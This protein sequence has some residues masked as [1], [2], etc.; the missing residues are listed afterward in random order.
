MSLNRRRAS[1]KLSGRSIVVC[2]FL[3]AAP[4]IFLAVPSTAETRIGE[5]ANKLTTTRDLAVPNFTQPLGQCVAPPAGMLAWYPGDG[6]NN[7]ILRGNTGVTNGSVL[8]GAGEVGQAFQFNGATGNAVSA[9]EQAAYQ[10]TSLTID[11]W[12]KVAA[13]PT[14]TQ[15]AG[16][17]FFRGDS[18]PALDPYFIYTAPGGKVGFHIESATGTVVQIDT[19]APANQWIHVAGTFDDPT[20]TMR[21]YV[22]GTLAVQ[23]STTVVPMTTMTGANPGIGIGNIHVTPFTFPFNGSI[24]EVELFGR[25]LSGAE[26]QGLYS[27]GVD[28]KCKPDSDADGVTDA[29][30]ACPATPSGSTVNAAGC[31][32]TE[33]LAPPPDMVAWYPGN[34]N[35]NDIVGG[36]Q[37]TTNG[38][39]NFAAGEVNQAF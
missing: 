39:V 38:S 4:A 19:P 29:L 2:L 35:N 3:L 26:I 9:P 25:A 17:I 30:D 11:A 8:F 37:G 23:Q 20:D 5:A 13:F 1:R 21:L 24:D 15:G 32:A 12:I 18:R 36:N 6:H 28:G 27:A 7:D 14:T 31:I 10:V 16:M 22:N 34:A 33:C